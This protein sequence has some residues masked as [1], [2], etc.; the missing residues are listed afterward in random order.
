MRFARW[1]INWSSYVEIFNHNLSPKAY[2]T[3]KDYV[4]KE[5]QVIRMV[6]IG[7]IIQNWIESQ[8]IY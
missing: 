1:I 8:K 6:I 4:F 3:V 7:H 2:S 5:T